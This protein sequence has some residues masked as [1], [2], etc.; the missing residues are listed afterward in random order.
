MHGESILSKPPELSQNDFGNGDGLFD[1]QQLQLKHQVFLL[2]SM[3]KLLP[4]FLKAGI[5]SS[6]LNQGFLIETKPSLAGHGTSPV[7]LWL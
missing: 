4:Q 3:M 2:Q 5:A 1:R 7:T 6:P